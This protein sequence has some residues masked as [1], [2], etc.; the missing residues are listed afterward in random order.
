M[1]NKSDLVS[2]EQL[3]RLEALLQS[4]NALIPIHR[5]AHGQ[6]D[7]SKIMG[8]N[9]YSEGPKGILPTTSI[10]N[11]DACDNSCTDRTHNH[12]AAEEHVGISSMVIPIPGPLT[13]TQIVE[14]DE[15]IRS[16]LWD[17]VLP[18]RQKP[19]VTTESFASHPLEILRCKGIWWNDAN[20][21]FVLQGV[22]DLYET[23][24][25]CAMEQGVVERTGK[26]VFIGKGLSKEV[27]QSLI[28]VVEGLKDHDFDRNQ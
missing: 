7:L 17:G 13:S 5:T 27:E 16:V 18:G 14:L 24:R 12:A 10:S 3:Q 26:I 20:E 25:V 19:D 23:S 9:A 1:L 11:R 4:I 6:I 22:R 28:H 15:W 8:L 21:Q 2:E